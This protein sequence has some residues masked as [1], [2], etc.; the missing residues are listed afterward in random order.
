[1]TR[2]PGRGSTRSWAA[3]QYTGVRCTAPQTTIEVVTHQTKLILGITSTVVRD[4]ASEHG[5]PI[6]RTF[7]WYAQDRQGNVWHMGVMT[8]SSSRTG[9]SPRPAIRGNPA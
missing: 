1:M 9:D 3:Y 7:D 4:V 2:L 5:K 8:R 6:E